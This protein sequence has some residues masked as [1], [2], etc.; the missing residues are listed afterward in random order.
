MAFKGNT[1][2]K[3]Q[4][5]EHDLQVVESTI[6]ELQ[7]QREATL[8]DG[9]IAELETL[10]QQIGNYT[11]QVAVFRDR[12]AGLRP[13]LAQEQVAQRKADRQK[14]IA[15]AEALLPARM[16]AIFALARWAKD[17]EQLVAKFE[18]ASKLE[19]WPPDLEKPYLDDVRP[20]R[21]LAVLARAVSTL[22]ADSSETIAD[23]VAIEREHHQAAIDDLRLRP[24][25]TTTS[26][27]EAA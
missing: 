20:D 17:G 4:R 1:A 11:R 15:K 2:D 18:Q 9:E 21:F 14:A 27:E 7:R 8:L 24:P 13:V 10:D 6:A 25:P 19:G 3:L 22:R 16:T 23:A 12:V 26:V 5:A